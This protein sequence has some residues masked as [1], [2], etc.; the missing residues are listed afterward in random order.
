MKVYL[1]YPS[2]NLTALV[3]YKPKNSEE[4]NL[5]ETKV[6]NINPSV[7]QIGFIYSED[8]IYKLEMV[9]DELCIN[10]VFSYLNYL[11]IYK[12]CLPVELYLVWPDYWVIGE[13]ASGADQYK[14]D[15]PTIY[16]HQILIK[17]YTIVELPG[18]THIFYTWSEEKFLDFLK[19]QINRLKNNTSDSV[20]WIHRTQE[21]TENTTLIP[22]IYYHK[23]QK[24]IQE[25][26]CGSWT[27]AF[28]AKEIFEN[29]ILGGKKW[30]IQ[31]TSWEKLSLTTKS[32]KWLL[33]CSIKNQVYFREVFDL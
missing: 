7:E 17:D 22:Y 31:Q 18:I 27:I 11:E 19:F 1:F 6:L 2:G 28:V 26:S 9:H 8:N 20:T 23:N 30:S 4:K 16:E 33:H 29:K 10:A 25:T 24:I 5:I 14:I 3:K 32:Q 12:Q 13:K 15:F 21:T